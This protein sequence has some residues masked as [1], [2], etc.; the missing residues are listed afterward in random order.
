[1]NLMDVIKN[2]DK[3]SDDEAIYATRD[4]RQ[5]KP[6]SEARVA[7]ETQDGKLPATTANIELEYFLEIHIA[8]E[9]IRV[10]Q[11][12]SNNSASSTEAMARAVIYYAEHDAFIPVEQARD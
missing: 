2:L 1:M 9:A 8:K 12:W 4:G 6:E 11:K 5:W 7:E 10:L 3:F